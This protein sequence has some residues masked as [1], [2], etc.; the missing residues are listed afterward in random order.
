MA[1]NRTNVRLLYGLVSAVGAVSPRAA[2]RLAFELFCITGARRLPRFS[3]APDAVERFWARGRQ[4]TS[5]LWQGGGPTVL[6][7]HGWGGG[8]GDLASFVSPL[9][10][11]GRRVVALDLPA[12]G[13]SPGRRL[14]L[15]QAAAA[16][17]MCL[18][19]EPSVEAVIA[20]S[21]GVPATVLAAGKGAPLPRAVL[22]SGPVSMEPY[23]QHFE[24]V[25]EL[26][27]AVRRGIRERIR[28]VLTEGGIETMELGAVAPRLSG[29]ALVIHD[30]GD[31]EVPFLSAQALHRAWPEAELLATEGLGHRRLLADP[32][33]VERAVRFAVGWD[34]RE[35]ERTAPAPAPDLR[36]VA[37]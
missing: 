35:K 19:R 34:G 4:V 11:A 12:H 1:E 32:V 16:V 5:Y 24:Q 3:T 8:S 29:R 36:L 13:R 21:F 23:L 25:L 6:L 18:R 28:R 20:H 37:S 31:R 2:G 14:N 30:R 17:E 9:R 15:A 26:A 27:P 33:V 22:I 10:D 7:V